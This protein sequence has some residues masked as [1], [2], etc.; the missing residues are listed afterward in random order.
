[1]LAVQR[2]PEKYHAYVGA[3]QMVD[4]QET[5]RR[6]YAESLAWAERTGAENLAARLRANGPPPY[7]DMLAYP[8]ALSANPEYRDFPH[9]EDYD[10]ASEYPASLFVPEYTLTEQVRGMGGILDTFAVLYPQ[11]QETD[12]RRDVPAL[13]VPVFVVEGAHESPGRA[14]LAREWFERLEAPQKE[15]VV[16]DRSGHTPHFDEPGRFHE[17]LVD[18]VLPRT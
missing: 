18:T 13:E 11:L 7:E 16:F 12:F 17:F 4:Q 6:M 14:D 10:P 3:G 1:M 15:L 5:D 8:D 9:G 2:A